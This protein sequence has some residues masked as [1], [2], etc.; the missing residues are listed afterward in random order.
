MVVR[1]IVAV[2]VAVAVVMSVVAV[3]VDAAA[4]AFFGVMVVVPRA[5]GMAGIRPGL[6]LERRLDAA[7][8]A[9]SPSSICSST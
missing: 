8:R 9:P 4:V 5:M 2:A 1:M 7:V 3:F 6:R